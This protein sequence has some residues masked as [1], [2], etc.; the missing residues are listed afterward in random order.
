GH[1]HQTVVLVDADRAGPRAGGDG[2]RVTECRRRPW[3][4]ALE[5]D[6]AEA[7]VEVEAHDPR[8]DRAPVAPARFDADRVQQQV[9]HGELVAARVEDDA[10]PEPPAAEARGG[11]RVLGV[12]H[13]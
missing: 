7:G 12:A 3:P 8:R 2:L 9:A 1:L 10:A 5:L 4:L 13:G 6:D 11:A